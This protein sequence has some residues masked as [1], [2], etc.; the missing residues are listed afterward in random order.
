MTDE[1]LH[2]ALLEVEAMIN[3]RPLTYISSDSTDV[4][5]LTPNHLLLGCA[6]VNTSP[7]LFQSKEINSRRRWRQSQVLADQ[8]WRRWKREYVPTLASR[9]KWLRQTRNIQ[10]GDVVLMVESDSPRGFWPLARVVKPFQGTDG[11]VRSVEL[12]SAGGGTYHR[13]V[14][15]VCLLE[16]A[17][18]CRH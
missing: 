17:N 10:E 6:S 8:F 7:G 2:T 12:R 11:V 3:G 5:P 1:V 4:E 16:E 14:S 13:P 15:K 18:D 9:Q